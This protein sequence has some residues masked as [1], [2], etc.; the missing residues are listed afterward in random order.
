MQEVTHCLYKASENSGIPAYPGIKWGIV[1]EDQQAGE[2][3]G[4]F[5]VE[6]L[7]ARGVFH[8]LICYAVQVGHFPRGSYRF[9]EGTDKNLARA[10]LTA[11]FGPFI[12]AGGLVSRISGS[13]AT[14]LQ[15]VS[16]ML[17]PNNSSWG[18]IVRFTWFLHGL[19]TTPVSYRRPGSHRAGCRDTP[20]SAFD[21]SG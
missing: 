19:I 10:L 18:Y 1:G 5:A 14:Y 6:L 17:R 7:P 8:H 11:T 16:I 9:D 15:Q 2:Q 20:G 12:K 3:G 13:A 4:Y 21:L